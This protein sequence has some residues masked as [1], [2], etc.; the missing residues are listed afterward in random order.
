V[1]YAHELNAELVYKF[2]AALIRGGIAKAE[3]WEKSN[4]D[5]LSFAK[6]SV[7]Q[8]I[9]IERGELLRRN[10]EFQM[11]IGDVYPNGYFYGQY[12][13]LE[14]GSLAVSICCSGAGAL[15][16]GKLVNALEHEAKGLG[17]AFYWTL[18]RSL[19]HVMRVYD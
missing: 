12:P 8:A 19:Y 11:E 14:S 4:E 3:D 16:L 9:G 10:V 6:Y 13:Q 1:I 5:A 18:I 15:R 2:C 17:A 7:M